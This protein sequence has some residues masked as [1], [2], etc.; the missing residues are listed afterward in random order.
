MA[1]RPWS[2]L[3]ALALLAVL[4]RLPSL[5]DLF[6]FA[7]VCRSWRFL[8]RSSAALLYLS[9]R[10]P[11]L[12]R[13]PCHLHR[14]QARPLLAADESDGFS[15]YALDD[16]RTPYRSL[17]P[18]SS[19]AADDLCLAYSHGYLILLRGRPR[20]DPV[21]ADV[22]TGAEILLPALPPDRVSFY[23]GT[24]TA[25]PA[26]PDCCLLLF[27]SRYSLMCCRIGEPHPEWARLP[28]RKGQSYIARVLRFKDRIFAISNI[29]R[30]LTLEFVPEFKVERLD[31]GGLHPPAAYDRW[32]FG[33]QL[34]E[35]GGELLAV[36]FVQEGRPWI[37]GIHVFRLDF[38]RMEWAQVESL[39]DHCLFID[40]GGKCPVSGVDPSC[41]GGRSNCVYVA[42]P[43]CDAWVE[44]SLDDKTWSQV[45]VS[46]G[47]T[48]SRRLFRAQFLAQL[49]EPRWPSPIWVYPSLFFWRDGMEM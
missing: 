47:D 1:H 12:L 5:L 15:L 45:S 29:G 42:A 17:F 48:I 49:G 39:G 25:P 8:L 33:P 19:A 26:S 4:R 10:P 34:V 16:L 11:L 7:A 13:P 43:G 14:R 9:S 41:W 27:Y 23:Y 44:Y 37:T 31:V 40:C 6:A 21:L 20:S 18:V 36:L 2:E 24:L 28:L 38:G 35:C 3:P 46:S 22:L 32:H 30:L